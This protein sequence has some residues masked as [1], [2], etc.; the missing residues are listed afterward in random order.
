M[1]WSRPGNTR[2]A[3]ANLGTLTDVLIVAAGSGGALSVLAASL[4]AFLLL[5]RRSD[6]RIVLSTED[7]RRLE[8]D[9]KR[10]DDV[11]TLVRRTLEHLEQ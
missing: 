8:I 3:P 5:P 7:G 6:I 1:A 10:V 2:R 11:E 4:K 9:A